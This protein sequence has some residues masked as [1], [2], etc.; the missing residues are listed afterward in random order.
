M[1]ESNTNPLSEFNFMYERL[2][3][4]LENAAF[5]PLDR[6]NSY[7]LKK[8]DQ[9]KFLNN[10]DV[11]KIINVFN[12]LRS[13]Y[14]EQIKTEINRFVEKYNLKDKLKIKSESFFYE[15]LMKELGIKIENL[16]E[17]EETNSLENDESNILKYYLNKYTMDK[18]KQL[19]EENANLR[20]ELE[21]LRKRNKL[22]L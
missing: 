2:I 11:N 8:C 19:E 4:F 7:T 22:N 20:L 21:N 6:Y 15:L 17:M 13:H 1:E 16:K 5:I 9:S 10:D 12:H 18:N 3:Q 14:I